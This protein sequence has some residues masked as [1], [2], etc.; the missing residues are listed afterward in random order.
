MEWIIGIVSGIISS[1]I[2]SIVIFL[3]NIQKEN[4]TVKFI[5]QEIY[6]PFMIS[7]SMMVLTTK[8]NGLK[9]GEYS[10]LQVL[11]HQKNHIQEDKYF[12][13]WF[14]NID[15]NTA[16]QRFY[17]LFYKNK[18]S[19]KQYRNVKF[20]KI[21]HDRYKTSNDKNIYKDFYSGLIELLKSDEKINTLSVMI[22]N[23]FA[24]FVVKRELSKEEARVVDGCTL[25]SRHEI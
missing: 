21:V 4:K 9:D 2:V 14:S 6:F 3:I 12:F 23:N 16:Y 25:L 1:S 17:E 13:D 18:I 11:E 10:I 22:K 8:F 20:L 19:K 15:Y 24:D 7:V 5:K